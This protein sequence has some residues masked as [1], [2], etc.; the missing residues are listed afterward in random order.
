MPK[1]CKRSKKLDKLQLPL[2]PVV[3]TADA[4]P[5]GTWTIDTVN[6]SSLA[7]ARNCS[8][9][10]TSADIVVAQ[11]LR[12]LGREAADSEQRALR[13]EGWNA[14]INPAWRTA[15]DAG[16]A[17]VGVAVRASVGIHPH[18]GFVPSEF[19]HRICAAWVGGITRGG[20]HVISVYLHDS[21]GLSERN[22][23]LLEV[24]AAA[25]RT[26][27][28]PWVAGG[29]WNLTPQQVG[30]TNILD[31]MCG[32]IVAPTM[33]TCHQSVYDYFVVPRCIAHAVVAVQRIDDAGLSPHWPTRLVLRSDMQRMRVREIVRPPRIP[34]TLP[35]GP[36]SPPPTYDACQAATISGNLRSAIDMWYCGARGELA[37]L[38]G[39]PC[40]SFAPRFRWAPAVQACP[41]PH[42]GTTAV[43]V[44]WRVFAARLND[45]C[46]LQL[47]SQNGT[48]SPESVVGLGRHWHAV[49]RIAAPNARAN[50]DERESMSRAARTALA[51]AALQ[52]WQILPGIAHAARARATRIEARVKAAKFRDWRAWLGCG[53]GSAPT[54]LARSGYSWV[55]GL[56]G[57]TR[58]PI[59]AA[60]RN[61][62][63][64]DDTDHPQRTDDDPPCL[65]DAD[66]CAGLDGSERQR[67]PLCDQAA[68][69]L[70]AE[71]WATQWATD[72]E[73][74]P[75]PFGDDY[76]QPPP[77]LAGALL[78]EAAATFPTATGVGSDN[79]GPRACTRLSDGALGAL[80]VILMACERVGCWPHGIWVVLIVLLPKP[81]GGLRPIGLFPTVVRIWMRAR[82]RIAQA[83]EAAHASPLLFGGKGMGAQRAAWVAAFQAEAAACDQ[84]SHVTA[85]LDLVKA[86]ERI[87]HAHLVR[88]ARR[89]GYSLVVLRLSLAAYRL[90]RAV[91]VEGIFSRILVATRGI[92]AGSGFATTELRVLLGTVVE[93]ASKC[94]PQAD[95]KLY[96]DDLTIAATAVREV[97]ADVVTRVVNFVVHHFEVHLELEV[98]ATKS[99]VVGSDVATA[100][101]VCGRVASRKLAPKRASKLLG[102]P[103]GG[104]RKRSV[105]VCKVRLH[106]FKRRGRRLRAVRRAGGSTGA[107]CRTA[108]IPAISYGWDVCGVADTPLRDIRAFIARA[109]SPDTFG[110]SVDLVFHTLDAAGMRID[111][112]VEAHA[113]PI[114]RWATAWWEK[115]V[116]PTALQRAH[117][118]ATDNLARGGD[119]HWQRVAGPVAATI[120]SAWRLGWRFPTARK[121]V[122]DIGTEWNLLRHPPA[123]LQDAVKRSV[124]RWRMRRICAAFPTLANR[125]LDCPQ[126][127][128][129]GDASVGSSVV[130][131]LS[132]ALSPLLRGSCRPCPHVPLWDASCRHWLASGIAGGQWP[133]VRRASVPHWETDPRCQLCFGADGTLE[134]RRSCPATLPAEGWCDPP[135]A[136]RLLIDR[137]DGDR[138]RLLRTRALLVM[139][140][141]PPPRV[142][143]AQLRWLTPPPD[144]TRCNVRWFI[145]GSVIDGRWPE[146]AVATAALV[147]VGDDGALLA[148]AEARLPATVLTAA[149][150]EAYGLMLATSCSV[151][152]PR[153]V[154]D[155]KS[156][157]TTAAAGAVRATAASRPLAGV[158]SIIAACVDGDLAQL[159]ARKLLRWIPAHKS[160][161]RAGTLCASDGEFVTECE[162]RANRLADIIART[163]ALR[164][165]VPRP[166]AAKLRGAADVLRTE[167]GTLGIVTKAANRHK[168]TVFTGGGHPT[169]LIKRD[170]VRPERPSHVAA[171]P[172]RKRVPLPPREP[173]PVRVRVTPVPPAAAERHFAQVA[174]RAASCTRRREQRATD[175]FLLR[176][177]L[178]DRASQARPQSVPADQRFAALRLRVA[179]REAEAAASRAS[180]SR[181]PA[182]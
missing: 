178:C 33:P 37:P 55:K 5:P 68:V 52:Y 142:S 61:D 12:V 87:P 162:W 180:S 57:W 116:P 58:S 174:A 43:A 95:L 107:Y 167:A 172:W 91:G 114:V 163:C 147:V 78:R 92:T 159:V 175:S 41:S 16:S 26:L 93:V 40:R 118:A 135:A 140:V 56:G 133:Q 121:L 72:V 9:H 115:W 13:K 113:L 15:A 168:V 137:L 149:A 156:L 81:D 2:P 3:G 70:E 150:A 160:L 22:L 179:A 148:F 181:S 66:L 155:C 119:R 20:M 79:I 35:A 8:F 117:I 120:A 49:A 48:L 164:L 139:R 24:L 88:A 96:V 27:R 17:G 146:L 100:R 110:R 4:R 166:V 129:D 21:E 39:L 108:G 75:L 123:A 134:H 99:I 42:A 90:G 122:D 71:G 98:S 53:P 109:A 59:D 23:A 102:A 152:T 103:Y 28:G 171:R 31:V 158:W 151:C 130:I 111:P 105:H 127:H 182:S 112:S 94:W 11:E 153:V 143:D 34:G 65:D 25:L 97:A 54:R 141:A 50:D 36:Q 19:A 77:A 73:Y 46:A 132:Y 7:S 84:L 51:A 131:D 47:K 18:E 161:A 89:H 76:E 64:D 44:D 67:A 157:L 124:A 138:V 10:R 85:L 86:F 82:S 128:I 176:Q 29:D 62:A 154:T 165:V 177:V 30:S 126:V 14:V 173:S 125:D 6:P 104:G 38:A 170:S 32:Q 136:Q 169:N 145:D 63:A 69:D 80:A 106:Q 83:W 101:S 60:K 144:F 1:R 74:P 45:I